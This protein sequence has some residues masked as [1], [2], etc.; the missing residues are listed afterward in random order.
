MKTQEIYVGVNGAT[1]P[2]STSKGVAVFPACKGMNHSWVLTDAGKVAKIEGSRINGVG[3]P[4]FL[5]EHGFELAKPGDPLVAKLADV[6]DRK[7]GLKLVEDACAKKAQ[8]LQTRFGGQ[9]CS[10]V[11]FDGSKPVEL[12]ELEQPRGYISVIFDLVSGFSAPAV[13]TVYKGGA[14]GRMHVTLSEGWLV[15]P[16]GDATKLPRGTEYGGVVEQAVYIL[17]NAGLGSLLTPNL[18]MDPGAPADA[19][20]PRGSMKLSL[21]NGDELIVGIDAVDELVVEYRRDNAAMY[22][23]DEG[24]SGTRL[25]D[26]IGCIAAVLVRVAEIDAAPAAKVKRRAA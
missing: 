6:L 13:S 12:I 19:P 15:C 5:K 10:F 2:L 3:V 25:G 11:P 4:R 8:E 26:V 23:R 17:A 21:V 1:L 14:N 16:E 18:A 9:V 20:Y 24:M 22:V 7:D